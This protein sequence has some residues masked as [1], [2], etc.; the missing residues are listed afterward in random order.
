MFK[1]PTS[2]GLTIILTGLCATNMAHSA[3][4]SVHANS[5]KIMALGDSITE[6]FIISSGPSVSY[7]KEFVRL[8]SEQ[9]CSFDMVGS[10]KDN[11]PATD[12]NQSSLPELGNQDTDHEG[13]S[14]I[15]AD[16]LLIATPNSLRR[17]SAG[18]TAAA[19]TYQPDVVLLHIGSNDMNNGDTVTNAVDEIQQ[20][21]DRIHAEHNAAIV[22]VAN[23]I[24]WADT[25][26][27]GNNNTPGAVE[28]LGDAIEIA[29]FLNKT[30]TQ[31]NKLVYLVD[32]RNE[33]LNPPRSAFDISLLDSDLIH[34]NPAGELYIAE[35]F[36]KAIEDSG[37]CANYTVDTVDPITNT[38][39][40]TTNGSTTTFS[41]NAT[42]VGGDDNLIN[43]SRIAVVQVAIENPAFAN[44]NDRW[45]NFQ[46]GGFGP[47]AGGI[48][49]AQLIQETLAINY[50]DWKFSIDLPNGNYRLYARAID[51]SG[52][53]E[54]IGHG[55]SVWPVNQ[56][57]T[58]SGVASQAP[59]TELNLV[60][61]CLGGNGRIDLNIVNTVTASSVY[62]L[63][64]QGL[65]PRQRTVAFE[66][67][68]RIAISGRLPGTYS[69]VVK[70]DGVTVLDSPV[71]INCNDPQPPVSSPE[72]TIVNACR[73]GLG[74]VFFQFVN[75]TAT[76][77]PY[78]IEFGTLSNRSTTAA[79]F[80]QARR[81]TTGRPNG[82][83]AYTVRTG[84][85]IVNDG[86][87]TVDCN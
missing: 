64:F 3:S 11:R 74:Q 10:K 23:L 78:V 52:N 50:A 73:S 69:A 72:V 81:G 53:N 56:L 71:T 16:Q 87:V 79:P 6:G 9:S 82:T 36:V 17:G 20:I 44:E 48:T 49:T 57:Y 2:I 65:S 39:E 34:P 29:G 24:P 76:P 22:F 15:T 85:T 33:I 84:S 37:V 12:F 61:S 83:Y 13:Y 59:K 41:G 1:N 40:A 63:E 77:R 21:I 27:A 46:S 47:I 8:L 4:A 43:G 60:S 75:P 58:I 18:V 80:G 35:A 25:I 70:R 62:R 45:W 55:L 19:L 86:Q 31:G 14:A 67:W 54:Y 38:F 68:G 26:V 30:D 28:A 7:R 42:D 32:V 5:M 66:D 51:T